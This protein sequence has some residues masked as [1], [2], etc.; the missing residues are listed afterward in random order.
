MKAKPFILVGLVSAMSLVTY[1]QNIRVVTSS[2]ASFGHDH[3]SAWSQENKPN[4]LT[5]SFLA[6]EVVTQI[7]L[8]LTNIGLWL[9]Q[10]CAPDVLVIFSRIVSDQS[11]APG[12]PSVGLVSSSAAQNV[13]NFVVELYDGRTKQLLWRGVAENIPIERNSMTGKR[14]VGKNGRADVCTPSILTE[15]VDI[16]REKVIPIGQR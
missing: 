1:A 7:N 10:G 13:G 2:K 14:A 12:V 15:W 11:M 4:P 16:R 3:S 6:D 5:G 9:D 8:H